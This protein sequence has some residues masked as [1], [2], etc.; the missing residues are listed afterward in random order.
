VPKQKQEATEGFKLERMKLYAFHDNRRP[1]YYGTFHKKS[2]VIK[3]RK[4]FAKDTSLDYEFDSDDEWEDPDNEDS[5]A[6]DEVDKEEEGEE[7]ES[8]EEEEDFL[9]PDG[10]LSEDEGVANDSHLQKL[11]EEEKRNMIKEAKKSMKKA[12]HSVSNVTRFYWRSY[13]R[14]YRNI[15][16]GSCKSLL[17]YCDR[18]SNRIS[19][20]ISTI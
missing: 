16:A 11:T 6:I 17:Q 4:P 10:Y 19:N 20:R 12:S 18:I 14:F 2:K 3:G 5:I 8:G 1:R 9:V 7:D 15:V 13:W